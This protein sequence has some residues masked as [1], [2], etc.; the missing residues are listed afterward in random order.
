MDKKKVVFLIGGM[1]KPRIIKR[2]DFAGQTTEPYVVYWK[3]KEIPDAKCLDE[4]HVVP[5][6]VNATGN[7]IG[8][9][10]PFV[11]F[12]F[13]TKKILRKI[14]P[15]IIHC[16]NLDMLIVSYSYWRKH[17][18]VKIVYEV[19]DLHTLIVDKQ[20]TLIRKTARLIMNIVERRCIKAIKVLIITSEQYY[21]VYYKS[22]VDK[23]KVLYF[24]NVPDLRCFESYSKKNSDGHFTIGYI[25]FVRYKKQMKNLIE[26]SRKCD[27]KIFI[28]GSENNGDE[29]Y[30]MCKD[31][32]NITW[33]GEFDFAH[34]AAS[35]YSQC[36]VIYSVYDTK[37]RNVRVALPNKLYE[38]VRCGLPIIV[39]KNTIYRK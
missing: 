20:T 32:P 25:G 10:F 1:I 33:H 21:E 22:F 12:F 9:A 17:R 37:M 2:I 6:K 19:P 3:R 11:K 8:R 26:A 36:D 24:P 18:N 38:S 35:L 4:S 16:Q 13:K 14:N 27:V 7:P 15:E 28:A 23:E 34:E 5:V 31:D 30:R 29:V 39:A